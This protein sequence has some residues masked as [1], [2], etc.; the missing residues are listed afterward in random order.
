METAENGKL[1]R[2]AS[3]YNKWVELSIFLILVPIVF[4]LIS[5]FISVQYATYA[6]SN[7]PLNAG[8]IITTVISIS[9]YYLLC[10]TIIPIRGNFGIFSRI[11]LILLLFSFPTL[12]TLAVG[13]LPE[14]SQQLE[15][16][17]RTENF[18]N[19]EFA[20]RRMDSLTNA[21]RSKIDLSAVE[22]Q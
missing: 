20:Q 11:A 2:I 8:F 5:R 22:G 19:S 6:N 21:S 1:K 18:R 9:V 12:L 10:V 4:V 14:E 15:S 7:D 3:H 13:L 17:G 16:G